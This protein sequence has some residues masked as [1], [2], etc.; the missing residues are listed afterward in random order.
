MRLQLLFSTA[1][2]IWTSTVMGLTWNSPLGSMPYPDAILP[3]SV[4]LPGIQL[5]NVQENPQ[6]VDFQQAMFWIY[7][8]ENSDFHHLSNSI[9]PKFSQ[10]KLKCLLQIGCF[11]FSLQTDERARCGQRTAPLTC[12]RFTEQKL[13]WAIL[14]GTLCVDGIQRELENHFTADISNS[15]SWHPS[16]A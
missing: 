6:T 3:D 13:W 11:E 1:D 15:C 4:C 10:S 9:L 8:Q 2:I 7:L 12:L 16:W 5:P 14:G